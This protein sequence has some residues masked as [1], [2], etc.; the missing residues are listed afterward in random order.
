MT[1]WHPEQ[2]LTV[3][4]DALTDEILTMSD[5]D[6]ALAPRSQKEEAK[7][8]AQEMRRLVAAAETG[9][10]TPLAP[11]SIGHSHST[12]RHMN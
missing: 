9:P 6:A 8:A 4:L 3:L 11:G 1:E 10:N 2:E 12:P 7:Q 5:C